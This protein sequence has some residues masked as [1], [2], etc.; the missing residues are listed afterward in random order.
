VDATCTWADATGAWITV[1]NAEGGT[2]LAGH[3][4]W[5]VPTVKE[6]QDLIDY[7]TFDPALSAGFPG[8]IAAPFYWSS[9][10]DANLASFAWGV[11]FG[12]G[13]VNSNDKTNNER[14]CAVRGGP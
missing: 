9:T 6:L 11:N 2:G 14:V 10:P 13:N 1:I 4:D 7:S 8:A 5:R 12:D 3:D